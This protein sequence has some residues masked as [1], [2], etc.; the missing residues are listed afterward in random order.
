MTTALRIRK[1][2]LDKRWSKDSTGCLS[3]DKYSIVS[4]GPEAYAELREQEYGLKFGAVN[5]Y[6]GFRIVR[7]RQEGV[8]FE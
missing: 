1:A 7:V 6:M 4:L 8:W 2:I 5:S 3:G